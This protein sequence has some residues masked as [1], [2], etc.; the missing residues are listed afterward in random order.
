MPGHRPVPDRAGILVLGVGGAGLNAAAHLADAALPGVRCAGVDASGQA[1]AEAR[2]RGL[3]TLLLSGPSRGL[4]CGGDATQGAKAACASEPE[5]QALLAGA[6]LVFV[7][8]GLGGGTGGGAAPYA[9]LLAR[10]QGAAVVGLGFTPFGFEPRRRAEA[11]EASRVRLRR[12]CDALVA[13]PNDSAFLLGAASL[14][15]DEALRVADELAR[16]AVLGTS[17]LLGRLPESRRRRW[18][19]ADLACLRRVLRGGEALVSLGRGH[20]AGAPAR[21]AMEAALASPLCDMRAL[22]GAE[23]ALVQVSGGPELA[24]ADVEEAVELLRARLGAGADLLVGVDSRPGPSD[25]ARVTLLAAG[26]DP[27]ARAERVE[28]A[29]L[30]ERV[31]AAT[32]PMAGDARRIPRLALPALQ[33]V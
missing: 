11:A 7:L 18:I 24:I 19:D 29:A 15:I 3:Q 6:E 5:L 2:A 21:A 16:Q 30:A 26:I 23:A 28:R 25:R 27:S 14:P 31:A 9:A 10:E 17:A 8:A 12:S 20:D 33:A 13:V 4:G 22:R 32:L 1:L